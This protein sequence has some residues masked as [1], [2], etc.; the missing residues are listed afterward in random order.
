[1]T[2][3]KLLTIV[4]F[5]TMSAY[6]EAADSLKIYKLG[7]VTVFSNLQNLFTSKNVEINH[8]LIQNRDA[9][10]FEDL[11][12]LLPSFGIQT[13]SRG[14]TIFTYRG[15]QERQTNFYLDGALLSVPWDGR[16]DLTMLSPGII[17]KIELIPLTGLYGSNNMMGI[18]SISTFE[19]SSDGFGGTV[20][21]QGGD[22]NMKNFEISHNGK[23]KDLSY[24]IVANWFDTDGKL[25]SKDHENKFEDYNS[26]FI[27][28]TFREQRNLYTKVVYAFDDLLDVGVSAN[29]MKYSKGVIPEENKAIN[30]MRFWRYNDNQRLLLTLNTSSFLDKE[31]KNNLR[32][33]Y[34]FDNLEQNIDS[35]DGITYQDRNGSEDSK[36]YSNGFRLIDIHKFSD[37][38]FLTLAANALTTIHK[39]EVNKYKNDSLTKK[40]I[41]D[42]SQNLFSFTGEYNHRFFDLLSVKLGGE[43]DY[44]VNPKTGVFVEAEGTDFSSFGAIAGLD[45]LLKNNGFIFFNFSNKSRFPSLR[46]SYSAALGKFKVNPDLKPE[47]NMLFELGYAINNTNILND[48]NMQISTFANF[49]NDMIVKAK[50]AESGLEM[51]DN[52]ASAKIYGIELITSF[53]IFKDINLN[54]NIAYM[55]SEGED[56]EMDIEHLDYRP[57]LTAGMTLSY[58]NP[59]GIKSQL[60]I[61]YIGKQYASAGNNV[62]DELDPTCFVNLRLGYD[63]SIKNLQFDFFV[64]CDNLFDVYRQTKIGIPAIGRTASAGILFKI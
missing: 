14:E 6:L 2:K 60:E 54:A 55:Y 19:R 53:E 63:L 1:M 46:E 12:L 8:E 35:Y 31:K 21:L 62:F 56:G 5:I 22:G 16:A 42:Y 50:D 26:A 32:F 51:R 23:I 36:D 61:D 43:F 29:Y 38:N 28:N 18:A 45:Y 57:D 33:T 30:K 58:K 34:W 52:I 39:E 15:S 64:R 3:L 9:T 49:Y 48:F 10:S 7:E 59:I 44:A 13:N 27:I 24:V 47:T 11:K 20:R 17:G 25:A 40:D 4:F 41:A 37:Y